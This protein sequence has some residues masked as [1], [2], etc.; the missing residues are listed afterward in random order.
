MPASRRWSSG[1]GPPSTAEDNALIKR[2]RSERLLEIR[3]HREQIADQA[4]IGDLENRRLLIL[5]DG[6]DDLAVLH[7]GQMLDRARNADRD[8]KIRRDDLAGLA[9]LLVV[10]RVAAS[11]AAREA[12]IAAPSLSASG[13]DELLK[14]LAGS[15]A[16]AA[17][18][19]DLRRG[20]FRPLGPR[21]AL[22]D[23]AD[24]ARVGRRRRRL[25]IGG[26]SRPSAGAKVGVRMVMTFFA[27]VD[28]TVWMALPA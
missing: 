23:E 9:D 5:V 28:C 17:G 20:Q 26:A 18:D 12:P 7:A 15:H 16:A 10:R 8:V 27:S 4:V 22:A 19:D 6:D 3:Q 11:T 13:L 1:A 14:V 24:R 25:S 21:Q 2:S